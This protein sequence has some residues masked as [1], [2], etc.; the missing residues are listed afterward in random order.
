MSP[1]AFPPPKHARPERWEGPWCRWCG[2]PILCGRPIRSR[3]DGREQP[4]GRR[5]PNCAFE[6]ALHTDRSVQFNH[7]ARRDG[8]RCFDCGARPMKWLARGP[9]Y[10]CG[11]FTREGAE[12][13]DGTRYTE[14]ERV[15]ALELEHDVPLWSTTHLT[16]DERRRFFGP[17][18][19]RLRCA[20]CHGAKTRGEAG[21]RAKTKRQ[22]KLRLDVPREP[23]ARPIRSR[24]GFPQGRKLQS[25]SS[26]ATRKKS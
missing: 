23:P 13:V 17:E 2:K 22:S 3:H 16:E 15:T 5:E 14:V 20:A 26:F 18:N 12:Y 6:Y 24:S 1:R 4:D 8:E 25:R 19:L 7:V 11:S 9:M 10:I 21:A